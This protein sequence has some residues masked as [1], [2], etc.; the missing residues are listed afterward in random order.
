[1]SFTRIRLR[2]PCRLAS[3]DW[4][5]E[6]AAVAVRSDWNTTLLLSDDHVGNRLFPPYVNRSIGKRARHFAGPYDRFLAVVSPKCDAP[7]V[8]RH[9]RHLV[10][11]GRK[12]EGLDLASSIGDAQIPECRDRTGDVDERAIAGD[13]ELSASGTVDDGAGARLTPSIIGTLGPAHFQALEVERHGE[14]AA[15]NGIHDVA[16]WQ[17]PGIAAILEQRLPFVRRQRLHDDS[18][19][20]PIDR[21]RSRSRGEQQMLSAR[22]CLRPLKLFC[23]H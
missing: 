9:P 5:P 3:L 15:A 1:M 10:R 16:R 21:D 7:S 6:Q 12:V 11:P 13:A 17:I 18:W 14:Q 23:P 19:P 2:Q 22:K 8:R 20:C 4:L